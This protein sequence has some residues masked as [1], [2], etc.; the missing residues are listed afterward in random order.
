MPRD[1]GIDLETSIK[2][3][4]VY[5]LVLLEA[6]F[7]SGPVRLWN[8][9]GTLTIDGTAYLG[10]GKLIRADLGEDTTSLEARNAIIEFA[11]VKPEDV[12]VA[13]NENYR[14]RPARALFGTFAPGPLLTEED[15]ITPLTDEEGNFLYADGGEF[16][17]GVKRLFAGRMSKMTIGLDPVNPTI[18]LSIEGYLAILNKSRERRFTH[19]DQQIEYPGDDFFKF[20]ASQ[21]DRELIFV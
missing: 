5:P 9:R 2:Q 12:G 7:D 18:I 3:K 19:E 4:L 11:G 20:I 21:Q 10:A 6:D 16:V 1:L 13:L 8:G 15:G 14:R 17:T